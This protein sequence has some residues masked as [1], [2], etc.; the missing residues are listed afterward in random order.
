[1][2]SI[3]L[4]AKSISEIKSKIDDAISADFKPTL[5]I[6]FADTSLNFE[7]LSK[8]F[9]DNEISIFGASSGYN[10]EGDEIF[11]QSIVTNCSLRR[12]EW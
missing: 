6:I 11:E 7:E 9:Q 5:A 1:M 8:I 3:T 4:Q 12:L 2:K 10:I